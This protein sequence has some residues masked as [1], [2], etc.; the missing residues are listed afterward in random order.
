[1]GVDKTEDVR[2]T[3]SVAHCGLG[4]ILNLKSRSAA[5]DKISGIPKNILYTHVHIH[6]NIRNE[7]TTRGRH[8]ATKSKWRG[9]AY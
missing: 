7:D 6:Q 9:G 3:Q 5:V 2:V 4:L 8:S 1:M